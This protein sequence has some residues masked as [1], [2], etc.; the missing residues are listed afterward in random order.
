LMRIYAGFGCSFM[1]ANAIAFTVTSIELSGP[2]TGAYN[3]TLSFPV[4]VAPSGQSYSQ[5]WMVTSESYQNELPAGSYSI[6]VTDTEASTN[7]LP[8]ICKNFTVSSSLAVAEFPGPV[9]ALYSGLA[10]LMPL[11]HRRRRLKNV[12]YHPDSQV[13]SNSLA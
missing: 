1:P 12:N 5:G 8:G 2:Y 13:C 4:P 9:I 3:T 10:F 7:G 11:H 6:S